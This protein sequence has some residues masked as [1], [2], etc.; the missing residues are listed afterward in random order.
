MYPRRRLLNS[1]KCVCKYAYST[2][3]IT[4]ST[5]WESYTGKV[6]IF[7]VFGT[8]ARMGN[9]ETAIR[10]Y[11]IKISLKNITLNDCAKGNTYE[12]RLKKTSIV[13]RMW[14]NLQ[15]K[16]TSLSFAYLFFDRGE[17]SFEFYELIKHFINSNS[18]QVFNESPL[19]GKTDT[20]RPSNST[21]Q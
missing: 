9:T 8:N 4:F 3:T 19:R 6:F 18:L 7:I 20:P 14:Y 17:A 21:S 11:P 10:K 5:S 13:T 16:Y 12:I 1:I 2:S 15:R